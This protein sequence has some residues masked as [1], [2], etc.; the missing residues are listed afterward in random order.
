M[1]LEN[2]EMPMKVAKPMD[3]MDSEKPQAGREAPFETLES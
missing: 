1:H 2:L 3:C